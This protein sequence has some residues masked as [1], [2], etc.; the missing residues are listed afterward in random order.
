MRIPT[1]AR[2]REALRLNRTNRTKVT[3]LTTEHCNLNKQ[4]A[5][6]QDILIKCCA[7][8]HCLD[9]RDQA[10]DQYFL[11]QQRDNVS[12]ITVHYFII[13]P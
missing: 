10:P 9:P 8:L 13:Y 3:E 5:Y 2:A 7:R 4:L 12:I 1:K 6:V 11:N